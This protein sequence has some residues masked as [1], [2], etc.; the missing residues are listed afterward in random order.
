MKRKSFR[1]SWTRFSTDLRL[2]MLRKQKNEECQICV[3]AELI[4]QYPYRK[5]IVLV[6]K[7]YVKA[8]KKVISSCLILSFFLTMFYNFSA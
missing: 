4:T 7:S 1:E 2:R 5:Q 8:N 6:V 3:G